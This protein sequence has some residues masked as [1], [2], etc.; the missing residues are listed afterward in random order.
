MRK[1]NTTDWTQFRAMGDGGM[2]RS[3]TMLGLNGVSVTAPWEGAGV[4]TVSSMP[5]VVF[6]RDGSASTDLV[7]YLTIRQNV[8]TDYRA[9]SVVAN[10]GKTEMYRW[11]GAAWVRMTQ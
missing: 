9:I 5:S 2:F 8:P 4:R 6:R 7:L 11:S 10:T 1:V 3:P